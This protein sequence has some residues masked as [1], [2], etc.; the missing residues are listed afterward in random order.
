MIDLFN[1]QVCFLTWVVV[2]AVVSVSLSY[3]QLERLPLT[4]QEAKGTY[5]MKTN[6]F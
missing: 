4:H 2:V 1:F 6:Y 3:F 5:L